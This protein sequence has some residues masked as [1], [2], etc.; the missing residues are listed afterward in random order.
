MLIVALT[1]GIASGKSVVARFLRER[2]CAVHSA[3]E[4]AHELL[5]A[6]EPAW[7]AVVS[8]FGEG[9]LKSDGTIDRRKLGAVVFAQETERLFLN[10]VLH[11]LVMEK[12]REAVARLKKE[13][14]HKIFVSEAALAI[15]S[16]FAS[17]YDKVIV[18][19]CPPEIQ[20]ER[21]MI[22]DGIDFEEARRKIRSQMPV[23]D[24][25]R[26]ADYLIDSS[27]SLAETE[28]RTDIVYR[29]LVRDAEEKERSAKKRI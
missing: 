10:A 8:H 5:A 21:L 4:T 15:E 24:K 2:G 9:V 23:E 19:F 13:G 11:P 25:K 1:G 29:R 7:K 6:G 14:R 12:K 16:G 27:G 26:R 22:R 18:V 20:E 28:R 3:D 17:F